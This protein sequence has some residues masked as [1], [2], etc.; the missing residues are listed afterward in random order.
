MYLP[1]PAALAAFLAIRDQV[2]QREL[3]E[4]AV[5]ANQICQ[6]VALHAPWTDTPGTDALRELHPHLT[7]Q[8]AAGTPE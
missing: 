8:P 5:R 3:R 2:H 6:A 1:T 4:L 7:P